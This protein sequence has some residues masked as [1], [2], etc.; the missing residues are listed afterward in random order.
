VDVIGLGEVGHLFDPADQMLVGRRRGYD[1]GT[2][3][4][5]GFLSEYKALTLWC[6]APGDLIS[7]AD[8]GIVSWLLAGVPEQ[9]WVWVEASSW[10]RALVRLCFPCE[11]FTERFADGVSRRWLDNSMDME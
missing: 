11:Y 4:K 7:G 8:Q 6:I 2:G 1:C 10:F 3:H 9:A 5:Y